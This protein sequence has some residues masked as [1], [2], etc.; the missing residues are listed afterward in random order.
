M[1]LHP[2]IMRRQ[3]IEDVALTAQA[4][5]EAAYRQ[6]T[7][8]VGSMTIPNDDGSKTVIGVDA[9][10]VGIAPW[11]GDTT[12]P[13]QPTGISVSSEASMILVEWP[14]TL[15]GG[16][17]PDFDHVTFLVDDK[18]VGEARAQGTFPLGPYDP[19]S[20]HLVSAQAWDDAHAE[21]GSPKP[22]GSMVTVPV[23]VKI[24]SVVGT[25][26]IQQA[27]QAAQIALDKA[28]LSET[29]AG[30]AKTAADV[31][32]KTADGKNRIF[33]A[34]VEPAYDTLTVGD[35]WFQLDTQNHVTG[36]Q[37]W[38]G[39]GFA[40]YVLM[41]QKVLVAGSVGAI[42][43]ADGAVTA[44]KVTASEALLKKLLVRKINADDI[45]VGSLT[46][47]IVSSGSFMTSD[48]SAGFDNSGF[49]VKS[50]DGSYVFRAG[51]NGVQATGGFTTASSG[52][53]VAVTQNNYNNVWTGGVQGMRDNR[54][55]WSISGEAN[56]DG[57]DATM[58][59]GSPQYSN[60]VVKPGRNANIG[61]DDNISLQG[62]NV[63]M[64]GNIHDN[65]MPAYSI[66]RRVKQWVSNWSGVPGGGD[67]SWY[68]EMNTT[69]R[70]D[71]PGEGRWYTIDVGARIAGAGEYC[72]Y[73]QFN[74]G[75]WV[76]A[77]HILICP[78]KTGGQIDNYSGGR[79][80]FLANGT[81]TFKVL[82]THWGYTRV[83]S[84]ETF[85]FVDPYTNP[86]VFSRYVF[87]TAN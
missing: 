51:R 52:N 33:A 62:N 27:Q 85:S 74:L 84:D 8:N 50:S 63:Y 59:L 44:E 11:V 80:I 36:I 76:A 55:I 5:M 4:A 81:Y 22:N 24:K 20:V 37:V 73:A 69:L 17:P 3:P 68:E 77:R 30:Q 14:G 47:A 75:N 2:L 82:T 13:G 23:S 34:K 49:W 67:G 15:S 53:R 12:P 35:L 40:D 48:R 29:L 26:Q 60:I 45:N 25:E 18:P 10:S 78:P 28:V 56:P 38:D 39:T 43:L 61:V 54:V 42:S 87:L 86:H 71:S 70:V 21:D 9:G 72:I 6:Q 58:R 65:G 32:V 79:Q 83:D 46:A 16:V 19:D 31:A 57:T 66:S 64:S 1:A 7:G 41:A